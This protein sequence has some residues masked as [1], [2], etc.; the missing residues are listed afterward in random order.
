MATKRFIYA[1]NDS[2][3]HYRF[4]IIDETDNEYICTDYDTSSYE[5]KLIKFYINK[6]TLNA[7]VDEENQGWSF[8]VNEGWF[9][10]FNEEDVKREERKRQIVLIKNTIKIKE[11]SL[12]NLLNL[13]VTINKNYKTIDFNNLQIGDKLYLLDDK[14][15]IQIASVICFLTEDKINYRPL[16]N[17]EK[18][19]VFNVEVE[20]DSNKKEYFIN[21]DDEQFG[22]TSYHIFQNEEDCNLY[23]QNKEKECI[24]DNIDSTKRYIFELK[25]KLKRLEGLIL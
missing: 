6:T 1:T 4:L 5:M 3:I 7:R 17:C 13:D 15:N 14:K 10:S 24:I 19:D 22:Y 16:I 9:A 2:Q 25:N 20:F 11:K 12:S 8:I 23:L 21:V 18:V